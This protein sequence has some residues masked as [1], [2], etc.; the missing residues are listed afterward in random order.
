MGYGG[1]FPDA[2]PM[3]APFAAFVETFHRALK[4][5]SHYAQDHPQ[6]RHAL[7]SLEALMAQVMKGGRP[8]QLRAEGMRLYI[9]GQ[10]VAG[11]PNACVMVAQALEEHGIRTLTFNST[12]TED[13]LQ[14]IF[15]AL[16]LRPQRLKEMGG[17]EAIL[18]EVEGLQVQSTSDWSPTAPPPVAVAS[19]SP[20]ALAEDLQGL[21]AAI[22]QMT[23][24]PL[25]PNPRSPWTLDQ[26]QTLEELGFQ[27]ASLAGLEGAGDQLG[28]GGYD[29]QALRTALRTALAAMDPDLQGALLLGLADFPPTETTL[30]RALDYL[31]PELFAQAL[32]SAQL[33]HPLSVFSL[34][35]AAAALLHCVKDRELGLEALKGRL[36]LEGWS[37]HD[38]DALEEAVRWECHGTDTKVRLTL[39]DRSIFDLDIQQLAILVRQ[40]ARS[41]HLEGLKELLNLLEVGLTSPAT[42]KR[43]MAASALA[44]LME[45]IADPGLPPELDSLSLGLLQRHLEAEDDLVATQW[46]CQALEALLAHWMQSLRFEEVYAAMQALEAY[47]LTTSAAPDWK[48]RLVRDLLSRLASPPNLAFLVPLLHARETQLNLPQLHGLLTLFGSPAAQYLVV[49]LELEED[50]TRRVH[51]LAA[52]RAIGVP[53]VPALVDALASGLWYM[54]RNALDLLTEIGHAGALPHASLALEHRDPRVR[55]SA[56]RAVAALGTSSQVVDAL[57]PLL[58]RAEPDFQL[59]I[60]AVLGELGPEA[61]SGAPVL[62]QLLA[63]NKGQSPETAR[64]RLRI[65][66]VLGRMRANTSV[67]ALLDLFRKK[68]LL[69]GREGAAVRIAAVKALEAI[70]TR[71]SRES[72]ALALDLESDAEIRQSIRQILV[73]S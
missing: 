12:P 50:R 62:L 57:V 46:S 28:L 71:E 31:A 16:H 27:T 48:R 4:A 18:S 43:T 6:A 52:L 60:L 1:A 49:C 3:S 19:T 29:P 72:L 42:D 59:A 37:L 34:A 25:R 41:R 54:A 40:M 38:V 10:V 20:R 68:G 32:V 2:T 30:R 22:L 61:V 17:P 69:S 58:S 13:D 35:L 11:S 67:P 73:N 70:G 21:F 36:M 14:L 15:F 39:A 65:L 66:E 26:R 24:M 56:L 9:D 47:G 33:R 55:K 44:D 23:V 51:L 8:F 7:E 64:V 63:D 45:C 53:A 5:Q